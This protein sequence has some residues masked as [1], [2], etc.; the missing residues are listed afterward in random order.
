MDIF[1]YSEVS[2]YF[3]DSPCSG[4]HCNPAGSEKLQSGCLVALCALQLLTYIEKPA[5]CA[6]MCCGELRCDAIRS[7]AAV[8]KET[9]H[10]L[11]IMCTSACMAWLTEAAQCFSHSS[12]S[13]CGPTF[14]FCC[15]S[16]LT[17]LQNEHTNT[18]PA[19]HIFTPPIKENNAKLS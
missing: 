10:V 15:F 1:I 16:L 3:P 2:R 18:V 7:E 6:R 5:A 14:H 13:A 17:D 8:G 4:A 11:W 12:E 19:R 9:H